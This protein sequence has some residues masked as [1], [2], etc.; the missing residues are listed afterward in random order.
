MDP[1]NEYLVTNHE[2]N[3]MS[4]YVYY[5]EK[6]KK[7]MEQLEMDHRPH[8]CR[9]TFAILMDN[10][11]ANKLSIKRP[12]ISQIKYIHTRILNSCL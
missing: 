1:N 11:G 9:H 6:W 10:A 12:R 2:N 7:I 5:H 8:D 4:Y 3:K